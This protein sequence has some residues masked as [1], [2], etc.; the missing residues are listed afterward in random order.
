MAPGSLGRTTGIGGLIEIERP[1]NGTLAMPGDSALYV[2]ARTRQHVPRMRYATTGRDKYGFTRIEQPFVTD[3]LLAGRWKSSSVHHRAGQ[4]SL[5]T[6][7]VGAGHLPRQGSTTGRSNRQRHRHQ[8]WA[9]P[10]APPVGDS[11]N[12]ALPRRAHT[13]QAD[14]VAPR[15]R[16]GR[17]R[18]GR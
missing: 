11:R 9:G 16:A 4:G 18:S 7:R 3:L 12:A 15:G 10:S 5:V 8:G 14:T 2:L 1:S 6:A 17:R 13:S